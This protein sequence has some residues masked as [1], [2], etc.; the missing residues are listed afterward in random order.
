MASL[1][2]VD[3][4]LSHGLIEKI[5]G[6][7]FSVQPVRGRQVEIENAFELAIA[8]LSDDYDQEHLH[9]M[10]REWLIDNFQV[11]DITTLAGTRSDVSE[12]EIFI[13]H[14]TTW[15]AT[16]DALSDVVC[17]RFKNDFKAYPMMEP[18][19]L[20][21][22]LNTSGLGRKPGSICKDLLQGASMVTDGIDKLRHEFNEYK[23]T[24]NQLHQATQLQLTATTSTL[25]TLTNTVSDM[26]SRLVNTQRAILFQSQELSL[27]RALTDVRSNTMS[28][29]VNLVL[30]RD[31]TKKHKINLLL[32]S[33][34]NE[35]KKLKTELVKTSHDFLDV[36]QGPSACQLLSGTKRRRLNVATLTSET[37]P[38]VRNCYLSSLGPLTAANDD[39]PDHSMK[40][41]SRPLPHSECI[42]Q[43]VFD[44]L[45]SLTV[46][47]CSSRTVYHRSCPLNLCF[48][49][50]GLFFVLSF[51][52]TVHATSPSSAT[53]TF[54]IYALNANGLVQPV[55]QS[56][57]NS[58]INARNPQAFV[59]GE[60]KTKSKLSNSLPCL[61]YDI[62][63][64]SGEQDQPHHPVK[65]GIVVGI[66]KDIQIAQRL[67]IRHKSLKGRV[68]AL[69]L[70]L[71]TSDGGCY[72]HR[73]FGVYAPWNPGDEGVSHSF[74]A[75]LTALCKSTK[76]AWTL[77]GDL[78]ATVSSFERTSGGLAAQTQFLQF[79]VNTDAHDL[80][81]NYPDRSKRSDW[82][83][84]GH[85]S[86]GPIP[87]GSI[88]DRIVT[89][90]C[91][92][93]DSEIYV[94][95]HHNDWIPFTDHRAVVGRVT[96][97]TPSVLK[98][99]NI[100]SADNFIRQ[101]SN[102]PHVKFPLKTEKNKYQVFADAVDDAIQTE[103]LDKLTVTNDE[104]F[105][106]LY[107]GLS[108]I[109]TSI[110]TKVFGKS[111]SYIK[112][113][114]VITNSVIQ[115]IVSNIRHIGGAIRFEKSNRTA[116]V[117]LKVMKLHSDALERSSLS[118]S[119]L[120][121]LQ[122]FA[123]IMRLGARV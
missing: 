46:H 84:R 33:L 39:I 82:T 111:K 87:E 44:T 70:V 120:L 88:I 9:D 109:I 105:L 10:L 119:A 26:E 59:L 108:M 30:E 45:R 41:I 60:T 35:E 36:V 81:T 11:D 65:W 12:P 66:R 85:Y 24:N 101:S 8:G 103:Q 52:Q 102:K 77:A 113:K 122:R 40:P 18:P 116:H 1:N 107:S 55:K 16:S 54:S 22:N 106:K 27:T 96:H 13:F 64:E 78:N 98:R 90:R 89:S 6:I 112:S 62:Y 86:D 7:P 71:P 94:V 69:D 95:N 83:C 114:E 75:D 25:S 104:T 58:A 68:I 56:N 91:T 123:Y 37:D 79:L 76:I 5:P 61:D 53:S 117:S 74:W 51:A 23:E 29:K 115:S 47:C 32:G 100:N 2:D 73:L 17:D 99:I 3:M 92:L 38:E 15:K 72:L 31:E 34:E 21:H 80:W 93:A 43:G 14:M 48:L 49:L 28:L 67:D 110:A 63:E 19:Q 121:L 42:F 20:L 4:I 57:I 118:H 97:I 50:F